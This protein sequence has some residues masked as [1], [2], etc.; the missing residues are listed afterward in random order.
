[1]SRGVL[2]KIYKDGQDI[3]KQGVAGKCLYVIQ[4]GQVE[5]VQSTEHGEQHL[6]FLKTGD[7][8]GEMALFEK[9][10]RSATI[11][12][13][14]DARILKVDKKTLFRRIQED[15]LLAVNLL[16]TMSKRIRSLS[17]QLALHE[18]DP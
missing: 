18:D 6:R 17:E 10:V 13:A 3:I 5:V 2:G 8:F 14:G 11:R 7:F 16:Q 15:P 12:A 1:M 9:E 4:S